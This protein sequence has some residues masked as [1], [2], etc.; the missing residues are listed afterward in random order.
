MSNTFQDDASAYGQALTAQPISI[1]PPTNIQ[2]IVSELFARKDAEGGFGPKYI[3]GDQIPPD[4]LR[5]LN[6]FAASVANESDCNIVSLH[7]C[8]SCYVG[9]APGRLV[10]TDRGTQCWEC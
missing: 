8:Q 4:K 10:N 5:T 3:T 1:E 6:Q 7:D 9:G 2:R